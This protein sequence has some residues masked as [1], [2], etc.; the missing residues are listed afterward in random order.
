MT[1]E[2]AI[3]LLSGPIG[4]GKT[5]LA[6]FMER[7][8]GVFRISTSSILSASAGRFLSRNELQQVGL[9]ERFQ[10]GEWIADA[11]IRSVLDHSK[12]EVIV[13]DAVRTVSQVRVIKDLAAGRWQILHVHLIA[14]NKQLARR[15]SDRVREG[16]SDVDWVM[17]KESLT[18]AAIATLGSDADLTIDT[19]RVTPGDVAVRVSSRIRSYCRQNAPCVDA[20][21]GGQ[22]GSEGKGNIAFFISPQYDLLVR[23]GAPNAGHRVCGHDG[24]IY[25]HRQLPSGTRASPKT[26]LLIGAGAVIDPSAL[27]REVAECGVSTDRLTIDPAAL[28]IEDSDIA[29]EVGLKSSIGSTGTGV[30]SAI[31]RRIVNRGVAGAVRFAKDVPELAPYIRDSAELLELCYSR[32]QFIL[33]E[34]TQGTGLSML[35]GSFP[36][37]TSRDTTVSALLSEVGIAPQRLRRVIVAFRAYPIRVAGK[38]GP[39]G[40][41]LTW[42]TIAER[43]GMHENNLSNVEVGSVSGGVRRV[44]EFSWVQLKRS[45]ILN[46]ATDI[47]LTFLD[48][49]DHINGVACRFDQLTREAILFVEEVELVAGAP[50]SLISTRFDGR[51]LIDRRLW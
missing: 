23:V 51:G 4:S 26:P 47:A 49:L 33:I 3:I 24:I 7:H 17:A 43:A 22:W 46:G 36:H 32:G 2:R 41:E 29:Q 50:V 13:V 6:E 37:V 9:A 5:T 15:Y 19:S 35:Y 48:Y 20:L 16:D 30:G 38:S 1:Y 18:E 12:I 21:V 45:A 10:G 44:A 34:G 40:Q 25:T 11:V 27:L 8:Y 42:G 39:M 28:I 14:E 31:A